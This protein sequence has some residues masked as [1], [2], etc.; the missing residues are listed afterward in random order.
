MNLA[1][2]LVIVSLARVFIVVDDV[3]EG[4]NASLHTLR[5]LAEFL[6]VF[7]FSTTFLDQLSVDLSIRLVAVRL[8]RVFIL[9]GEGKHVGL[10]TFFALVSFCLFLFKERILSSNFL[11]LSFSFE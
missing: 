1:E 6:L 7:F 8:E 11:I 10:H 3:D 2:Y 4:R 5:S 9:V